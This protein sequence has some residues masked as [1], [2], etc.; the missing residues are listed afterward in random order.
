MRAALQVVQLVV[1]VYAR[2]SLGSSNQPDRFA[3][4]V[5]GA[6]RLAELLA[7][8]ES[9][10]AAPARNDAEQVER[11]G[12]GLHALEAGISPHSA[13]DAVRAVRLLSEG[14]V[15]PSK[16]E[17]S[18]LQAILLTAEVLSDKPRIDALFRVAL[19]EQLSSRTP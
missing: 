9:W 10:C 19:A 4:P 5:Q 16:F 18:I 15:T 7:V 3:H 11:L 6:A 14:L 2:G 8:I 1:L 17:V 13:R 12:G